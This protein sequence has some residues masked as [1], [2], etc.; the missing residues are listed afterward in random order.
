MQTEAFEKGKRYFQ[1]QVW[2]DQQEFEIVLI[3]G[4]SV[5]DNLRRGHEDLSPPYTTYYSEVDGGNW[6][7]VYIKADGVLHFPADGGSLP[8]N[9]HMRYTVKYEDY[10]RF[11]PSRASST[12]VKICRRPPSPAHPRRP[13]RCLPKTP[14][15]CRRPTPTRRR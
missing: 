5:P 11:T 9:V 10:R 12:T 4:K 2:V 13:R 7:P 3:N 6:F 8:N 1:G 15:R 14:T